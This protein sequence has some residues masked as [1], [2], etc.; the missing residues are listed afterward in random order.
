VRKPASKSAK[1]H[2]AWCQSRLD[3]VGICA[4]CAALIGASLQTKIGKI[5]AM[6]AG[7]C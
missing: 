1:G 6:P 3:R 5:T 7:V 2:C 4:R